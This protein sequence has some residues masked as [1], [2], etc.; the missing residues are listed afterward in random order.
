MDATNDA[1]EIQHGDLRATFLPSLG[2]LGT[3]LRF[4]DAEFVALPGGIEAYRAGHQTG[5]PFL[6]PW[7]N[8]PSQS[9]SHPTRQPDSI[10]PT[11][12]RAA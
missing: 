10:W 8:L 11:Q 7:A 3:S 1:M 4:G 2:M 5:L 12:S 6:A 9:Q